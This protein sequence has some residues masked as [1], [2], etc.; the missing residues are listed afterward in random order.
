[1][2]AY[3]QSLNLNFVLLKSLPT[4]AI[5]ASGAASNAANIVAQ[6]HNVSAEIVLL[7]SNNSQSGIFNIGQKN[8]INS[9]L[10]DHKNEVEL[11]KIL[12]EAKVNYII[13]AGYLK[14]I[15]QKIIQNFEN[16]ILNIHPALLPNY[17]GKG[18][19]GMHVHNAV[20]QNNEPKTG[21]TI[22]I[23]NEEFD[24]GKILFQKE[25]AIEDCK[26]AAEIATK[27]QQLEHEFYPKVI[28]QFVSTS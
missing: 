13:L 17:G 12:E 28:K 27:V 2:K 21:I 5:F 4:I 1:M 9:K 8:N 20:F 24:K 25:V 14:L 15:P 16:K 7:I 6:L 23:V 18:M 22:H 10:I 26:S 3:F 19:Y 11:L